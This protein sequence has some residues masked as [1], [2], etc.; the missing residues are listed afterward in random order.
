MWGCFLAADTTDILFYVGAVWSAEKCL[1]YY[2][3]SE[4]ASRNQLQFVKPLSASGFLRGIPLSICPSIFPIPLSSPQ[5]LLWTWLWQYQFRIIKSSLLKRYTDEMFLDCINQTVG[6]DFYVHFLEV[7]TGVR[8]KL[9][10]WDTQAR[11]ST[12]LYY[13][14][15]TLNQPTTS[16]HSVTLAIHLLIHHPTTLLTWGTCFLLHGINHVNT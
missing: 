3:S 7:E 12:V 8:V 15:N 6:V 2:F 9:Q 11:N 1:S 4:G 13:H 5:Q 10:F 16:L 14:N